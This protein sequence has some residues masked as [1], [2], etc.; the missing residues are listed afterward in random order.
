M[1][2]QINPHWKALKVRLISTLGYDGAEEFLR[3]A[4]HSVANIGEP[5]AAEH[6]AFAADQMKLE[7]K[8][9]ASA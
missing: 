3:F 4:S 8:R 2:I 5:G 1:N 6:F 7:G 9:H